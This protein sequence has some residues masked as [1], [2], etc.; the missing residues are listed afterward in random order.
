MARPGEKGRRRSSAILFCAKTKSKLNEK[1]EARAGSSAAW[2]KI[3][4]ERIGA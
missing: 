2:A 3:V 1:T 4:E